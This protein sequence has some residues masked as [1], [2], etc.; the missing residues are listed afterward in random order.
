M[1]RSTPGPR[2]PLSQKPR[3][4]PKTMVRAIYTYEA[5]ETDELS[6]NE[7][8]RIELIAESKLNKAIRYYQCRIYH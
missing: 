3:P 2:P 8:D 7:N 6:F 1:E 4:K 5:Q